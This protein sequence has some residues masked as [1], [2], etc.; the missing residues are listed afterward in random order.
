MIEGRSFA[1]AS[2]VGSRARQEDDWGLHAQPPV[3]EEG[4]TLLAALADG[5]GGAPAGDVAGRIVVK[6]FLDRCRHGREPA[7]ERLNSALQAANDDISAEV[8]ANGRLDGMGATL[9]AALFVGD[10]CEWLS[11]GD[12]RI[13]LCRDGLIRRVNPLHTYARRLD[14][15]VE[16]G[17]LP[18][19]AALSHPDRLMLTSVVMGCPIEEVAQGTLPLR[20]GDVVLLASDGVDT[21]P[22]GAMAE[23]CERGAA[24]DRQGARAQWIADALLD[25]VEA[26]AAPR[27]DNATVIV[28]I[29]EVEGG[30]E[31]RDDAA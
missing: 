4:A 8:A 12:S 25:G 28:V 5:M 26:C 18:R 31:R 7:R 30:A 2:M 11:V 16:R 1:A 17:E 6:S 20:P 3:L 13:L 9:V 23:V 24:P 29:P 15:Q 10:A 27:Q 21:L 14:A 22:S 19:E